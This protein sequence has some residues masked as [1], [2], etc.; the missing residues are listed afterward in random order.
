MYQGEKYSNTDRL[1]DRIVET[2]VYLREKYSS[3]DRL[4]RMKLFACNSNKKLAEDIA[5]II[6]VELG[7]CEVSTFSDGEI[8]LKIEQTVRNKDV[9]VIQSTC[10]PVNNN[11]MELLIMTDALRRASAGTINVVVPY[12]G[13]ARQDRKAGA[14]EPISAKLI[15]NLLTV[16]GAERLISMDLHCAQIQGFFDIPVDHLQG[17]QRLA[18]YYFKKLEGKL[19][20][21]VVVSA[22]VGSITRSRT[23]AA[24]LNVPMAIIDKRR[25]DVNITEIMNIIGDVEGKRVILT[26][27]LIDT[28]GTLV[29][30]AK[31]LLS[32]G[33]AKIYASCVHG[34]LSGR[35]IERIQDSP[36][37]ELVILDTIPLPEEKRIDKI[38]VLSVADIFAESICRIHCGESVSDMFS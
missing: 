33:A 14:H 9:Y 6:G 23:F 29:N 10:P 38:I 13:Y 28:A 24:R 16:A 25:P 18:D 31:A 8:H 21:I 26:D 12:F 30:A 35:A 27:D 22:D 11:L 20:D 2:M 36:I 7:R 32:K 5:D 15:A 19:N 4:D 17:E 34:V 1:G 3:T 37:E